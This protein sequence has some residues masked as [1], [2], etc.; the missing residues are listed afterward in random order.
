MVRGYQT[1]E[2]MNKNEKETQEGKEIRQEGTDRTDLLTWMFDVV[3]SR[4]IHTKE[5]R[6]YTLL[7]DSWRIKTN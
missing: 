5:E 2:I 3:M 7:N 6:E 1:W 4:L